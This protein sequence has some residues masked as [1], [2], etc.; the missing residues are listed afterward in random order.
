[1]KRTLTLVA[2]LI[3]AAVALTFTVYLRETLM[4][5]EHRAEAAQARLLN[6]FSF[7][8]VEYLFAHARQD[9][10]TANLGALYAALMDQKSRIEALIELNRPGMGEQAWPSYGHPP[11]EQAT[12]FVLNLANQDVISEEDWAIYDRIAVTWISHGRALEQYVVGLGI[13]DPTGFMEEY[14][15][16]LLDLYQIAPGGQKPE[17]GPQ[18]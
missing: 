12:V 16:L 2:T 17:D 5:A 18:T 8:A 15:R 13:T 1:M 7:A 4:A 3:V 6:S 11:S 10:T 9:S 14:L